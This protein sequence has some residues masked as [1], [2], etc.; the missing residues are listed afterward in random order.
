MNISQAKIQN[1]AECSL[2]PLK[3]KHL[4]DTDTTSLIT[5]ADAFNQI[6]KF[7]EVM[8]KGLITVPTHLSGN[9]TD[10]TAITIQAMQWRM[11]PFLVAQKT[12]VVNGMISYEDELINAVVNNCAPTTGKLKT[13]WH[14][15][16]DGILGR[17][18]IVKQGKDDV[19]A[20]D[21]SDEDEQ[22]LYVKVWATIIGE[23]TPR[24]LTLSM[25]QVVTRNSKLWI[26][27]PREQLAHLA[28]KRWARMHCPEVVIGVYTPEE[29]RARSMVGN[30]TISDADKK[31]DVAI[32]KNNLPTPDEQ[33]A[34]AQEKLDKAARLEDLTGY[35]F[36]AM[37][38]AI[39]STDT[40]KSLDTIGRTI[41]RMV[42]DPNN[43]LQNGS[44]EYRALRAAYADQKNK[45]EAAQ[46]SLNITTAKTAEQLDIIEDI[47]HGK[48]QDYSPEL[49]T[50]L[51]AGMVKARL[52]TVRR[53][54]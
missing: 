47:I 19:Y 29:V 53:N 7:A 12:H 30:T 22:G 36:E 3:D 54:L 39:A 27:D 10:C 5:D 21:W 41:K 35:G 43:D 50:E 9:I 31:V 37:I 52:K 4:V 40:N 24:E 45:I 14:G 48:A 42:E 6:I 38:E 51:R 49:I 1:A 17:V 23:D 44:E 26:E 8:S 18:K 33:F 15:D 28:V 20:K 2:P 34:K 16:W 46:I 11:N 25:T 13:E 32:P